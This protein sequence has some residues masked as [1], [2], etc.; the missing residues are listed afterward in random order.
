MK[1]RGDEDRR[2]CVDFWDGIRK[3]LKLLEMT[4]ANEST[5][6][7]IWLRIKGAVG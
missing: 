2:F 6:K 7:R 4:A 3:S 5:K 1:D